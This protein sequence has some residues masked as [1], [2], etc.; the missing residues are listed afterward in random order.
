[1]SI[2]SLHQ[3]HQL[4][5]FEK[6]SDFEVQAT[7]TTSGEELHC[8]FQ[9]S[10]DR[11]RLVLPQPAPAK[12]QDGLWRSTCCEAFFSEASLAA[13]HEPDGHYR[14]FNFSPNGEWACYTFEQYRRPAQAMKTP[15]IPI[16]VMEDAAVWQLEADIPL[17]L[18]P[19]SVSAYQLAMITL[20]QAPEGEATKKIH[21]A[22]SHAENETPD[23]HNAR[24]Y[25]LL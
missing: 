18:L 25:A 8:R 10:G 3:V 16:R 1:M 20:I 22:I 17:D 23:F 12:F 24:T 9:L 13:P 4:R 21:W 14:E 15:A 7:M 2:Q 5:A 11:T 6:F 19:S